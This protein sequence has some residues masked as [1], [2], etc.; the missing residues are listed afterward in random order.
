MASPKVKK[1]EQLKL[2][3]LT[4]GDLTWV[5]MEKPTERETESWLKIIPFTRWI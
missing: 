3:S 1:E 4:W 2:E 5:N